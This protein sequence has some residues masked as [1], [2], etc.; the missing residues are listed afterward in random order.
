MQLIEVKLHQLQQTSFTYLRQN[1]DYLTNLWNLSTARPTSILSEKST[2]THSLTDQLVNY[3]D[4]DC[5]TADD[6][7]NSYICIL[8]CLFFSIS[9]DF[10]DPETPS[11]P[12]P[13]ILWPVSSPA[14]WSSP[15]SGTC[16]TSTT[17]PWTKLPE[18]VRYYLSVFVMWSTCKEKSK[19]FKVR[20]NLL[21]VE[22]QI[23][24]L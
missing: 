11:S 10:N 16:P 22:D 7:L 21:C 13:S 8:K 5:V 18:T 12:A 4:I 17:S 19:S 2:L 23:Q 24:S 15:S 20:Q 9:F 3:V 6:W 1:I 14:S